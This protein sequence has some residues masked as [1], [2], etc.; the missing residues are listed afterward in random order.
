MASSSDELDDPSSSFRER[1]RF[2]SFLLFLPRFFSLR[3]FFASLDD[4]ASLPPPPPLP[5]ASALW[6]PSP[7]TSLSL[8]MPPSRASSAA[9]CESRSFRPPEGDI[10]HADP[11]AALSSS[12]VVRPRMRLTKDAFREKLD[13]N[14]AAPK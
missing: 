9:I 4:D 1:E 7:S 10:L 5:R 12:L 6:L 14:G 2:F 8:S 11:R 13:Q 3:S